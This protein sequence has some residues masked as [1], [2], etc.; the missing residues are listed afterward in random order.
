MN[1]CTKVIQKVLSLTQKERPWLNVFFEVKHNL[2][3]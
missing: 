2:F 1:V 3:S